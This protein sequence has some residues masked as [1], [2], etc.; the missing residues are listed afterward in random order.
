MSFGVRL[1]CV[2]ATAAVIVGGAVYVVR[3]G[4]AQAQGAF[5]ANFFGLVAGALVPSIV[6]AVGVRKLDSSVYFG[7]ALFLMTAACWAPVFLSKD[8]MRGV[9]T[10]PGFAM[11]LVASIA[12]V[13]RDRGR[14]KDEGVGP[15]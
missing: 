3:G 11:T 14:E 9:L 15:A 8:A 13:S 4:P 6:Y 5:D 2:A 1:G 12:G 7:L 10:F